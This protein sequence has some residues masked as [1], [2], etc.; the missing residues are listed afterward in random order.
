MTAEVGSTL[1]WVGALLRLRKRILIFKSL[2]GS[3]WL[4]LPVLD[5]YALTIVFQRWQKLE[6]KRVQCHKCISMR[7]DKPIESNQKP[8]RGYA[9][10]REKLS[11]SQNQLCIGHSSIVAC[12]NIFD[13]LSPLQD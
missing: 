1:D 3:S 11:S 2:G 12:F 5:K 4:L 13:P 10:A 6:E 9:S 7:I 8:I